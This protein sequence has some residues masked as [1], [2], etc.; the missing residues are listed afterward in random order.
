[1]IRDVGLFSG[2]AGGAGAGQIG[3]MTPS[4]GD[5]GEYIFPYLRGK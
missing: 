4:Q 2:A 3:Q 1:M 5:K